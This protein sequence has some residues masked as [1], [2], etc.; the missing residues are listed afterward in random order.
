MFR[1]AIK[2]LTLAAL[3]IAGG[4][5]TAQISAPK[6]FNAEFTPSLY[7]TDAF[8]GV[9]NWHIVNIYDDNMD[10]YKT[11]RFSQESYVKVSCLTKN[12]FTNSGKYE[13]V[14]IESQ[15]DD[16]VKISIYNEDG[17][18]LYFFKIESGYTTI[19]IFIN[20]NKLFVD[21]YH[22]TAEKDWHESY[23]FSS[24]GSVNSSVPPVQQQ[25]PSKLYPNPARQSVILEY[26]IQ[27]QMQEM[28]IMD[29][30]G[31]VVA[32]YLLDPSQKQV[33]INTS[34]YKKGVYIYRYGNNSGKFI[35]E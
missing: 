7:C 32:N 1:K 25:N 27:G 30:Q 2:L 3:M 4:S 23:I 33:N 18:C 31:R 22:S 8:I 15:D 20:S 11:V 6:K 5:V 12:V 17:E 24:Q 29:M 14:V 16:Y 19:N 28:Q 10:I 21:A 13:F 26:D 35:V 9:V 34:N